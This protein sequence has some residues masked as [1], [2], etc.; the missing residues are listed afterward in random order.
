MFLL[1]VIAC[2]LDCYS[3]RRRSKTLEM[4]VAPGDLGSR[5]GRR[6]VFQ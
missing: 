6:L 4:V 2:V 3:S 1:C 5:A